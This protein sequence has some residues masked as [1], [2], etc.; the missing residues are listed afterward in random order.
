MKHSLNTL[1]L[2]IA[3]VLGERA[4][5]CTSAIVAA[6]HSKEHST[7]L[8][9]HRDA[10]S[11]DCHIEH[12]RDGKYPFTALV[13]PDKSKVYSGINEQGFAIL[14]TVSEN[15]TKDTS[16]CQAP[17]ALF[18]MAYALREFATVEE[19]EKWLAT[20]NGKRSYVTN[21][22]VGDASGA[23]A[24]FEVSQESFKRYDIGERSE[25]FDIRS[26]FS[27]SGNMVDRGP[28]VP[29]YDI[30]KRQ[31]SCKPMH[32]PYDFFD[33][34]RNY[35]NGSGVE[36]LTTSEKFICNDLTVPRYFSV[37]S[38]VMVCDGENP[39]MLV[40][41]GHPVV[42]IVVP[43]YVK[44]ENAI[45]ECVAARPSLLL[46]EEFRAKAYTQLDELRYEVNKPLI[47]SLLKIES[48]VA[49][50]RQMP[51]NIEQFNTKIDALFAKHA[52]KVRR[53]L[54]RY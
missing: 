20:T 46:S 49:M 22:A 7:L 52:A 39:R 40:S 42:A 45:P 6:S 54:A 9:K 33:Y 38:M 12:F 34:G 48:R 1:L 43:V 5:A 28:S 3:L 24:Y 14:N 32:S 47:N 8:W 30:V 44:A 53:V 50:P 51:E 19:F 27:F 18:V 26:N 25:G 4:F 10:P 36:V 16:L 37:A 21:F 2:L 31:M 15:I 29:R 11:W 23:A 35:V 13:S 17:G 41:V